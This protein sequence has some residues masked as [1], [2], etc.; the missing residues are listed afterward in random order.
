MTIVQRTKGGIHRFKSAMPIALTD[1]QLE[2]ITRHA[3]RDRYLHRVASLF[4]KTVQNGCASR[5]R[6]ASSCKTRHA[7]S[8]T[9]AGISTC[10]T[11][12]DSAG[13]CGKY[14]AMLNPG[15][16]LSTPRRFMCIGMSQQNARRPLRFVCAQR[17]K[18]AALS[19]AINNRA[20]LSLDDSNFDATFALSRS[21]KGALARHCDGRTGCGVL[22]VCSHASRLPG[23][24]RQHRP[25]ATTSGTRECANA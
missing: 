12:Q 24:V 22:R 10:Q 13:Q 7:G 8:V 21:L 18:R 14:F 6:S 4:N 25:S 16:K 11:V 2:I 23:G 1:D 9:A 3:D 5:T 19:T 15:Y 20:Q 17:Q